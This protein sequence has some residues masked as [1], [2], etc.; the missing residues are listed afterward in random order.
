MGKKLFDPKSV[1]EKYIIELR[2]VGIKPEEVLVYG[3]YAN[4][5]ADEWSDIDLVVISSDFE[6][7]PPIERLEMLSLATWRVDAPIEALGYT[8]REI[9]ENGK[10]SIIWEAIQRNHKVVYKK[11]A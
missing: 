7:I 10:D 2:K 5:K 1:A 4:G 8:P 3:S 9:H 6:N 11:A